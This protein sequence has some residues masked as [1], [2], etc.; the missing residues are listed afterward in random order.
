MKRGHVAIALVKDQS[1]DYGGS[2]IAVTTHDEVQHV[3]QPHI[4]HH[5]TRL[6]VK[7]RKGASGFDVLHVERYVA[8]ELWKRCFNE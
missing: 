7:L 1:V 5:L 2:I 6:V 4:K 8:L 3:P